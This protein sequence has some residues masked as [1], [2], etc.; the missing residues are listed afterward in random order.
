M[1]CKLLDKAIE[2][3]GFESIPKA[4]ADQ[5]CVGLICDEH[6]ETLLAKIKAAVIKKRSVFLYRNIYLGM[7]VNTKI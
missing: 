1:A 6:E 4:L 2:N 3:C 7:V 5:I